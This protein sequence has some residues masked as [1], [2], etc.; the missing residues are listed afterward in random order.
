MGVQEGVIFLTY[1]SLAASS[2]GG[3]TRLDQ[4]VEWCG[5]DFDGLIVFDESHKAKNLVPEKGRKPTKVGQAVLALQLRLPKAR[6][7][8]CSATGE[9]QCSCTFQ[10]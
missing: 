2:T 4:L 3:A 5:K 8:Y 1:T 10:I 7:V 9:W 6:I